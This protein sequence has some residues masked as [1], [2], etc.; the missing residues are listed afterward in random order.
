MIN[1]RLSDI[2][3]SR[4]AFREKV[5]LVSTLAHPPSVAVGVQLVLFDLSAERIAVDAEELRRPR[6]VAVRAI[7]HALDKPF[8]ELPDGFIKED[9]PFHHLI[10]EPFQLIFHDVTLR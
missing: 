1:K 8:L 3:E 9:S 6:L 5:Q 7:Q 2:S 10:D 4:F